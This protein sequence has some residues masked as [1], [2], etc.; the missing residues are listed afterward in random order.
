MKRIVPVLL[1]CGLIFGGFS[2]GDVVAQSTIPVTSAGFSA[3]ELP[4][5]M[6]GV[7]LGILEP[8]ADPNSPTGV[9]LYCHETLMAQFRAMAS[10]AITDSN[11]ER[12]VLLIDLITSPSA[13]YNEQIKEELEEFDALI[14][15]LRRFILDLNILAS[16]CQ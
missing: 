10:Q 1:L 13:D 6:V 4:A 16:L 9:S 5:V 12:S 3:T 8:I 11:N 2:T 7:A 15:A 14:A